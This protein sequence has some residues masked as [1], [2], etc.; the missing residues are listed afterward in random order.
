MSESGGTFRIMDD[1]ENAARLAGLLAMIALPMVR[2]GEG[3]YRR[4]VIEIEVAPGKWAAVDGVAIERERMLFW[5]G[6]NGTRMQYEFR[7]SEGCPRWRSDRPQHRRFMADD[8]DD[9][10]IS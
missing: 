3:R 9:R 10:S 1:A 4:R 8:A 5:S 7:S 6:N 2:D